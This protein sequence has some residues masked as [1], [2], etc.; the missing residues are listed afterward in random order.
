MSNARLKLLH[1][2]LR[3]RLCTPCRRRRARVHPYPH[4]Q[5]RHAR[6]KRVGQHLVQPAPFLPPGFV[7]ETC[8]IASGC[9]RPEGVRQFEIELERDDVNGSGYCSLPC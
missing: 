4:P 3:H 1:I 9:G 5:R 8:V 6:I 7:D 2:K